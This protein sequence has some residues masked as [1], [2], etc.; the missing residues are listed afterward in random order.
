[1]RGEAGPAANPHNAICSAAAQKIMAKLP[2]CED[3]FNFDRREAAGACTCV[4]CVFA[5]VRR[6]NRFFSRHPL[7]LLSRA[8]GAQQCK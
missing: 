1:M 5:Y 3:D 7:R 8:S 4:C 2:A 6:R